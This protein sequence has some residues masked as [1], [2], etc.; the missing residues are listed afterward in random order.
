MFTRRTAL[1]TAL[2]TLAA[3]IARR[4][5][6]ADS[7]PKPVTHTRSSGTIFRMW[8]ANRS[9]SSA[10]TTL[11]GSNQSNIVTPGRSS[12]TSPRVR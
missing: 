2:G 3:L 6:T 10:W 11:R 9:S 8:L 1:Q 7:Q 12:H 5:S 4:T